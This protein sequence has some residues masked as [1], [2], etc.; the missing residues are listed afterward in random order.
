MGFTSRN[1]RHQ[2]A[3]A[4]IDEIHRMED[5]DH[6]REAEIPRTSPRNFEE[7]AEE[8]SLAP[9]ERPTSAAVRRDCPHSALVP[10]WAD[11]ADL[12][13]QDR[14]S[15]YLCEACNTTLSPE[16]GRLAMAREAERLRA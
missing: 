7:R 15:A 5:L 14:I 10:R 8:S 3:A 13:K 9:E 4:N 16:E 6:D 12:G 1:N 2:Q 11:A